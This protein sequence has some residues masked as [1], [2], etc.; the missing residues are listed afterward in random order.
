MLQFFFYF[1]RY[2]DTLYTLLYTFSLYLFDESRAITAALKASIFWNYPSFLQTPQP[3]VFVLQEVNKDGSTDTT[4]A[5]L[6]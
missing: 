5:M 4:D 6:I 1:G 3:C 2:R